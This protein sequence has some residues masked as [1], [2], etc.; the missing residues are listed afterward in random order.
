MAQVISY[1]ARN[2]PTVGPHADELREIDL[3]IAQEQEY[4]N[5]E[6]ARVAEIDAQMAALQAR[7]VVLEQ[8]IDEPYHD[9]HAN[10]PNEA[11][12]RNQ[13]ARQEKARI[14]EQ[15]DYLRKER[16]R[17]LHEIDAHNLHIHDKINKRRAL[18]GLPPLPPLPPGQSSAA[19]TSLDYDASVA[20][21]DRQLHPNG[22]LGNRAAELAILRRFRDR[23]LLTGEQ[24]RELTRIY[25]Q[26]SPALIKTYM[27]DQ[28]SRETLNGMYA[29]GLLAARALDDFGPMLSPAQQQSARTALKEIKQ[30]VAEELNARETPSTPENSTGATGCKR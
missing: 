7:L 15:L 14:Q 6:H 10:E 29:F 1:F 30:I 23:F 28:K 3:F 13:R 5:I 12:D 22:V 17:L 8:I 2:A 16:L 11:R 9:W 27:R 26:I 24:G 18:L 20:S 25:Y 4:L 21:N 19:V